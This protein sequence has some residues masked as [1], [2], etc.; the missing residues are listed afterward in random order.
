[1]CA[2]VPPLMQGRVVALH[3]P[4]WTS[5]AVPMGPCAMCTSHTWTASAA[6][7][8]SSAIQNAC[9]YCSAELGTINLELAVQGSKRYEGAW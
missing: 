6:A 9:L 1:M 5:S 4:C 7:A 2:D 3:E 8:R